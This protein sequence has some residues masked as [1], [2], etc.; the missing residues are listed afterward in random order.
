MKEFQHRQRPVLNARKRRKKR[1]YLPAQKVGAAIGLALA[2][3]AVLLMAGMFCLP[4][5]EEKQAFV[6]AED[7]SL[8]RAGQTEAAVAGSHTLLAF[9]A[10]R[11]RF[12]YLR[13][14]GLY[15]QEKDKIEQLSHPE[16]GV[17]TE[18]VCCN[19]ALT[20]VCW[21]EYDRRLMTYSLHIWREGKETMV[22][23]GGLPYLSYLRM[24][25]NEEWLAY[26]GRDVEGNNRIIV[27]SLSEDTVFEAA[28]SGDYLA[29]YAVT[30]QGNV[31]YYDY[32]SE[33]LCYTGAKGSGA[34]RGLAGHAVQIETLP[35]KNRIAVLTAE[36]MLYEGDFRGEL[37]C[38]AE[39]VERIALLTE[40]GVYWNGADGLCYSWENKTVP[41]TKE[42]VYG[43]EEN[44]VL[45]R[46]PEGFFRIRREGKRFSE[47]L[48][49]CG[50]DAEETLCM[51][52]QT[53]ACAWISDG[54]LYSVAENSDRVRKLGEAKDVC[55]PAFGR[56][57]IWYTDPQG[58][59]CS[60]RIDGGK[61]RIE[62]KDAVSA[63]LLQ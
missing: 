16:H 14:D 5:Q 11:R 42:T 20:V 28:R 31:L 49:L 60:V 34:C 43:L 25:E 57:R 23:E 27:R 4:E 7:G 22:A 41:V 32:E 8:Y 46:T 56:Y 35:G 45:I 53:G 26:A 38:A 55:E 19:D 40:E 12:L 1:K 58:R 36:G 3:A 59:L 52:E 50:E 18:P 24:S 17:M 15:R 48:F 13:E 61:N 6:I 21:R 33:E 10:E 44:A 62:T 54:W 47:P 9:D 51:Q 2:A 63:F 30:D 39:N 29:C 37:S